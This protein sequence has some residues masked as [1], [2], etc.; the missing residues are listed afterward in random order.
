MTEP[1]V[2]GLAPGLWRV[3]APNPSAFTGPGTNSYL[4]GGREVAVIDPGPDDS[5]HLAAILGALPPGARVTAILVTHAHRDHSGLARRLAAETG[6]PV[7]AFGDWTA[8]RDP[9]RAALAA[10]GGGEGVDR[11]FAPDRRLTDGEEVAGEGWRIA[12]LWTPGHMGNHL[13]FRLGGTVFTGDLVMGWASSIISPP[14]GDLAAFRASLG[15]LAG[16]GARRFLPGHGPP[17]EAPAARLAELLA[18]RAEREASIRAA[19]AAG[20]RT[21]AEVVAA[22]YTDTPAALHPAALRSVLAHLLDLADRGLAATA[23]PPGPAAR[24][25]PR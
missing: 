2:V 12:A 21:A 8:G 4:V 15:R 16:L 18:H 24:W 25:H 17:V 19:L 9:R 7:F 13:S 5:R 23:D 22:V 3:L 11:D 10:L 14:D 1:A 6:A 20:C